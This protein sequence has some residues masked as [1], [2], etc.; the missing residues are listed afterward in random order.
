MPVPESISPSK[1]ACCAIAVGKKLMLNFLDDHQFNRSF[2]MVN[3]F[4]TKRRIPPTKAGHISQADASKLI[5]ATLE[6]VSLLSEFTNF[7]WCQK[8]RFT[9]PLCSTITPFGCPVEPEV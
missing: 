9:T 5:L 6:A 3:C 2:G 4:P 8:T 1:S 7:V